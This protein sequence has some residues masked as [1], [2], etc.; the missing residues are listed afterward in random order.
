MPSWV[1]APPEPGCW[2]QTWSLPLVS[3][4]HVRPSARQSWESRAG[5]RQQPRD[6]G[7]ECPS[8][9]RSGS[10]QCLVWPCLWGH[11]AILSVSEV[12]TEVSFPAFIPSPSETVSAR[13]QGPHSTLHTLVSQASHRAV[14]KRSA[15]SLPRTRCQS[16]PF[17]LL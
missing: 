12:P 14:K 17:W 11:L 4:L 16:P 1:H 3:G 8:L 15:P 6:G 9:T 10:E 7:F 2:G 13:S 5:N